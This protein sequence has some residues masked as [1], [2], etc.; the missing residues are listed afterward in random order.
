MGVAV[1]GCGLVG[2]GVG[3][4]VA[5]GGIWRTVGLPCAA[6][7]GTSTLDAVT[8]VGLGSWVGDGI[9][10]DVSLGGRV[11]AG[12]GDSV[13][14]GVDVGTIVA[15]AVDV[16]VED[17]VGLGGGVQSSDTL[18]GADRANAIGMASPITTLVMRTSTA[19]ITNFC[20]GPAQLWI[21]RG[22]LISVAFRSG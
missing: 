14:G 17:G 15:V 3:D 19:T 21:I 4:A 20:M 8:W 10:V 18:A 7:V 13:A 6:M 16:G 1:G 2:T 9:G 11:A 5:V 22:T 12:S